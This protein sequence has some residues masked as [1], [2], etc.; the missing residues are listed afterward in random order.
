MNN[1]YYYYYFPSLQFSNAALC[2]LHLTLDDLAI[3]PCIMN[4]LLLTDSSFLL[5]SS[6]QVWHW[7]EYPEFSLLHL[8]LASV[9][10]IGHSASQQFWL[11]MT[12]LFCNIDFIGLPPFSTTLILNSVLFA[13][14]WILFFNSS[15]DVAWTNRTDSQFPAHFLAFNFFSTPLFLWCLPIHWSETQSF[16]LP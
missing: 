4:L 10:Q 5:S 8:P 13:T 2:S 1:K 12:S 16:L 14:S 6:Q 7:I 9:R 15:P 3:S 11:G